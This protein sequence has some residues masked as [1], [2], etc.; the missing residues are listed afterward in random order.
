MSEKGTD[1]N[2]YKAENFD[3]AN[4]MDNFNKACGAID[5]NWIVEKAANQNQ[6]D[7]AIMML[8]FECQEEPDLLSV[9]EQIQD[10]EPVPMGQEDL[11]SWYMELGDADRGLL[12]DWALQHQQLQ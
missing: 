4:F 8:V 3:K 7:M 9:M 12:A 5:T 10:G 2:D 11:L 1:E 6:K